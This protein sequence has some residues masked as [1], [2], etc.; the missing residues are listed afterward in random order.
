MNVAMGNFLNSIDLLV[1]FGAIALVMAI[2]VLVGSR[3][4]TSEDYFLAGKNIPWWGVAG[5]IFGSNISANHLVGMMGIGFGVGFAQS[6]FEIGAIAALMLLCYGFLPVYRGLNILTLSEYLGKRY[7]ERSRLLYAL[8]M[9]LI[10]VVVQ[11]VPALYIGSRTTC[12]LMGGEFI[13]Q[14]ERGGKIA[15][16]VNYF[17]YV[18]VVISLALISASYTILGGLKAVIWTDFL[19]S[20]LL[21]VAGFVLAVLTFNEIG[22]WSQLMALDRGGQGANKM[23]LYLPSHHR[24]LPWTG[25]LTGLKAMDF[26]Y[27]GTNQFIVQRALAARSD[28]EARFG[29]IVAGFL[30]LTIPFIAIGTG[31]AAYYLFLEKLP[32]RSIASDAAFSEL[33]K[34]VIPFGYGIVG[35]IAAGVMGAILSSIDSMMNSAATIV[36]V[37]IYQRYINPQASDRQMIRVGRSSIVGFVTL[38]T[39]MAILVLDPNSEGHFFLQIVDYQGYLTPGLLVTFLLG[40][41]WR[42]ATGLGSFVTICV[43]IFYSWI[44]QAGYD[45]YLGQI[46]SVRAYF[47]EELN[48]FHRVIIVVL[49]CLLTHILIS[50]RS[51]PDEEKS[52]LVWTDLGG[53]RPEKLRNIVISILATILFLTILGWMMVTGWLTTTVSAALGGVWILAMFVGSILVELK[54]GRKEDDET[55]FSLAIFLGDDRLWA[56]VLCSLAAF[57]LYQY[58]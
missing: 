49:L 6:H 12:I 43:G 2:G 18:I 57:F 50:L 17:Y 52:K 4:K 38:A 55:V 29:V 1:F 28:R 44:V 10:M 41:F 5:S 37:D 22:G 54:K 26:Y 48:I 31:V 20:S 51:K 53:H 30:K 46:P 21:L 47:G 13:E 34:L 45:G 33:V 15:L 35:L 25:V 7:D 24:E 58:Y 36:S 16:E 39:L 8:I 9:V 56:G 40:I 11:M 3:E 32:E 27:W 42:R 23:H 19:Q 14:V